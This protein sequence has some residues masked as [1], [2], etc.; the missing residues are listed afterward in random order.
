M[1]TSITNKIKFADIVSRF[2]GLTDNQLLAVFGYPPFEGGDIRHQS[3][4]YVNREIAD[5][6]QLGKINAAA[7]GEEENGQ[8]Q[9]QA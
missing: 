8:N 3:L 1:F 5:K 6:Y 4:N 2:G 7:M 9:K